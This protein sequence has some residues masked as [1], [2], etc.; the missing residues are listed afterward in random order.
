MRRII[1]AAIAL[2][3]FFSPVLSQGLRIGVKGGGNLV[4]PNGGTWDYHLG[5]SIQNEEIYASDASFSYAVGAFVNMPLGSIF[6]V[7]AEVLFADRT[8]N[9]QYELRR[10]YTNYYSTREFSTTKIEFPL[11]LGIRIFD[12]LAV[13]IGPSYGIISADEPDVADGEFCLNAGLRVN[14]LRNLQA[15]VRASAGLT[16]LYDGS[17]IGLLS[18]TPEFGSVTVFFTVGYVF[19]L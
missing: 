9:Y 15:D 14:I 8:L 12:P 5:M 2:A 11:L 16:N 1:A 18:L 6:D 13:Y 3:L 10:N 4:I 17:G 7:Q 19:E